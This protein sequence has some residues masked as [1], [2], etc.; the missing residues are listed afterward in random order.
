MDMR[1]ETDFRRPL[2]IVFLTGLAL[3]AVAV[4]THA[5]ELP[6]RATRTDTFN[7]SGAI[8]SLS[9]ENINGDVEIRPGSEFHAT[10]DVT[11]RAESSER[12]KALLDRTRCRFENENGDL[13]L[14]TDLPGMTIR[15]NRR[16]WSIHTPEAYGDRYRIEAR[17]SI[18]IPASADLD[19]E[20]VNGTADCRGITG[21]LSL[22][23]V[24]GKVVIAGAGRRVHASTVNGEVQISYGDLPRDADVRA[25]TINGA[26]SV[27][28]PPRAGFRLEAETMSGSIVS[29][30]PLPV[31]DDD[32]VRERERI[33]S[34]KDRLDREKE[35]AK[36]ELERRAER[37]KERAK[38]GDDDFDFD[39]DMPDLERSLDRMGEELGR[40]GE[41]IARNVVANLH[42]TYDGSVNG[43]GATIHCSTLNGRIAVLAAGTSAS[44]AKTI[45]SPRS[46]VRV[47]ASPAPSAIPAPPAPPAAPAAPATPAPV[48]APTPPA[49]PAPPALADFGEPLVRG[50]V[51]GDFSVSRPFGDVRVGRVAG[52]VRIITYGGAITVGSAEKGADLRSSGGDIRIG[53][54][55]GTVRC[56]TNGGSLTA[57][58]LAG[59]S[60]LQTQGGD[61][62][63]RSCGGSLIATTG[64]GD[65]DIGKLAGG[66]RAETG[67]GSVSCRIVGR[68]TG[69]GVSISSG[70]GDVTL[71]LPSN[72]RANVLVRVSGVE[73]GG[74]YIHSD[75]PEV[76]ISR[77]SRSSSGFR[78]AE[79]RLNGGGP[80]VVIRISS[81]TVTLRK[82]PPA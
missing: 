13:S 60:R 71:T 78:T 28:L 76:V 55:R 66:L 24:N 1:H 25:S 36:R 67:G 45:V 52:H 10:V 51:A 12:A 37:E 43:G 31:A 2:W 7:A 70:A 33:R 16:G 19:L 49:P 62:E 14:E 15:K 3:L 75:F 53:A 64:G 11:V 32:L 5:R 9:L 35:R 68:E 54:A 6:G 41:E 58:D 57:G 61:I 74:D 40:M 8:H 23:S 77:S 20:L 44:E 27:T 69:D 17:Y 34:A 50:D 73:P 21:G 79:G 4:L 63:V 80:P 65:I 39:F 18:V 26:V 59:D 30:F 42:R 22:S 72:F 47:S 82:G 38:H 29:T 48:I 46:H 56:I 81:G